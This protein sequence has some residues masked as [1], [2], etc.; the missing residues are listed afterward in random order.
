MLERD[1][2]LNVVTECDPREEFGLP[3]RDVD[4]HTALGKLG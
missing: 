1:R 2:A 3:R 4:A